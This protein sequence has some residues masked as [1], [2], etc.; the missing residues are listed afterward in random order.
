MYI[1]R[2]SDAEIKRIQELMGYGVNESAEKEK[3]LLTPTLE[4]QKTAADGNV[5]GI[6]RECNKFYIKVAKPKESGLVAEDF[7]Y[8]GGFNNKKDYEY[9]SYA[10]ASKQFDLKMMSLNEAY[11][12]RN[13]TQTFKPVEQA[14]W[15]T[16]MTEDMRKEINRFNQIVENT[17]CIMNED[18][19]TQAHTLPEAP[20]KNPSKKEVNS[21]FTD[22]AVAELDKDFD[23]E[24]KDPKDATSPYGKSV[25]ITNA[26]MRSD[27]RP[28]ANTDATYTQRAKYVPNN[29]V[30]AKNPKGGKAVRVNEDRPTF[31]MTEKQVLAWNAEK[32]FM[33]TS[34]GTHIGSSA[35]FDEEIADNNNT[36]PSIEPIRE[37]IYVGDI[38]GM[39]DDDI[40]FDIDMDDDATAAALADIHAEHAQNRAARIAAKRAAR[41]AEE[42]REREAERRSARYAKN[43]RDDDDYLED[44]NDPYAEEMIDDEDEDFDFFESRRRP[45]R[46]RVNEQ[47]LNVFGK[48]PAYR[49]KPM[50]TPPNVETAPNGAHE[51]DDES[52]KGEQPYGKSKGKSAPFDEVVNIFTDQVLKGLGF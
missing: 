6:L 24:L 8:I 35:P 28:T 50:T 23:K 27:R 36:Q 1:N 49:K 31:L 20:S 13:T 40:V 32:D 17:G 46:K 19:F 30:A 10:L 2:D 47:E 16:S 18:N 7:T 34:K 45:M 44:L 39:P 21:P 43:L 41:D 3:G 52:A 51:W 11:G 14:D 15:Q 22:T 26:Q 12:Q 25:N 29:A 9:K 4:Y 33:D 48:H 37:D 38:A 42:R 5:Y